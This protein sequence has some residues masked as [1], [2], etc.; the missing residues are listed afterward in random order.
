MDGNMKVLTQLFK[1]MEIR[2]PNAFFLRAY[3][4][5]GWNGK[6]PYITENG[7]FDTGLLPRIISLIKEKY[8]EKVTLVDTRK[9]DFKTK[10]ITKL[11]KHT[12]RPYQVDSI[13]SITENFV[14]EDLYFPRGII[15]AATNSGKTMIGAGIYHAMRKPRTLV[16]INN[17]D[18]F[19][20]MVAE[21]PELLG[22]G[23]L[24]IISSKKTD[25]QN[26]TVG[27]V[28]TIKSR[29][30]SL[31]SYLAS[32]EFILVDECDLSDNKT[33]K[34]IIAQVF[35]ATIRVG[36]S[37]TA[38][39]G[40]LAKFKIPHMNITKYFG[41]MV[42]EIRNED[43]IEKGHSSEVVIKM[44]KGNE[45]IKIPGNFQEEYEEGIVKNPDR[46]LIIVNRINTNFKKERYP[47]LVVAKKHN[48]VSR[49]YK[50]TVKKF[51]N[52]S[53]EWCHHKRK[54]RKQI[55]QEFREGKIDI[56]ISSM[57]VK[58]G[59]NFPHLI[60]LINAG[61]GDDPA[62]P[63]QLLGRVM[64]KHKDSKI[65]KKYYE[66]FYDKGS[67]LERHSKHRQNYYIEENLRVLKLYKK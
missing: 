54:E 42:Y 67:Y 27:M 59:M 20:Q 53:V 34:S 31:K 58:R 22:E 56:L 38:L 40:K 39:T 32:V 37:G 25:I 48:H 41:E 50:K 35:N 29:L 46:N 19:D 49:L 5:P 24:G 30:D 44:I 2:H 64:R 17:K 63:L 16:L 11:N 28:G 47:I 60:T 33:Y 8:K 51:P 55:I 62:G 45:T 36:M 23:E 52:L 65:T 26:F 13:S 7:T 18:L 15:K 6:I 21:L 1:D 43:L 10:K 4:R 3:M 9:F 12:L 61:G 14:N 66:D 57:I